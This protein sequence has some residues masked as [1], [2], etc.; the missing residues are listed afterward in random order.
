MPIKTGVKRARSKA[1]TMARAD[2]RE[3]SCS[4]LRP[5]KRMATVFFWLMVSFGVPGEPGPKHPGYTDT[6]PPSRAPEWPHSGA[7]VL[8]RTSRWG[9]GGAR[10]RATGSKGLSLYWLDHA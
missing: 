4:A 10:L 1:L 5:P 6:N 2:K 8:K 3:T 7:S 9:W